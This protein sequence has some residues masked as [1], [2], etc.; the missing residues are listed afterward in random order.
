MAKRE[1]MGVAP[2]ELATDAA[3]VSLTPPQSAFLDSLLDFKMNESKEGY[4]RYERRIKPGVTESLPLAL[5][6]QR[7]KEIGLTPRE[8]DYIREWVLNKGIHWLSAE[9]VGLGEGMEARLIFRNPVVRTIING[10][11]QRGMC[12]GTVASKD[13]V[14][15][16]YTQRMRSFSLPQVLRDRAAEGLSKLMGYYPKEGSGGGQTV[17]VQINCVNPYGKETEVEVEDV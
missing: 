7:G 4:A 16:Y 2:Q 3:G 12:V 11:S 17:N 6:Y 14:A 8:V 13:E 1:L 5:L 15:D 9:K 10:A